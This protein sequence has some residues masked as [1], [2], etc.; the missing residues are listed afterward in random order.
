MCGERNPENCAAIERYG[1]I[2][3]LGEMPLFTPLTGAAVRE[4]AVTE[5]DPT[6]RL[7][8]FLR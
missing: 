6:G 1:R 7:L 4:W 5:L 8:E 3:V 2:R